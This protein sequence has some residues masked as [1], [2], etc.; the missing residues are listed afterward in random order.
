MLLLV[1]VED[2]GAL[3]K[4]II[5]QRLEGSRFSAYLSRCRDF[6]LSVSPTGRV[7]TGGSRERPRGLQLYPAW[8][9]N[10]PKPL[11]QMH[12]AGLFPG[13]ACCLYSLAKIGHY[14][15]YREAVR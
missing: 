15:K 12:R 13:A 4:R 8:V 1:F 3:L 11:G 2:G 10:E 7:K 14:N 9:H 5:A 6:W